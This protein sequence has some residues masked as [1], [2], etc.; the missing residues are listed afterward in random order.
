MYGQ[1]IYLYEAMHLT[2]YARNILIREQINS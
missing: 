2:S 1:N